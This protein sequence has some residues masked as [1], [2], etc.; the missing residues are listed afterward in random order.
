MRNA[1]KHQPASSN[2][3]FRSARFFRNALACNV[4][5]RRHNF[6]SVQISVLK[7]PLYNFL[8][9]FCGNPLPSQL[10]SEPNIQD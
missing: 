5:H 3:F 10:M 4:F 6:N 2:S 1:V 8:H 9:R 7:G